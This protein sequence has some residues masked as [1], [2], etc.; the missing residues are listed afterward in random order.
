MSNHGV[1]L[2]DWAAEGIIYGPID[3]LGRQ[4]DKFGLLDTGSEKRRG[5]RY[6]RPLL[7]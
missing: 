2:Q 4:I 1:M 5:G 6:K 3:R 7:K